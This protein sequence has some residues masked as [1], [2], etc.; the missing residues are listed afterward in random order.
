MDKVL[1]QR[2]KK[3]APASKKLQRMMEFFDLWKDASAR[4]NELQDAIMRYGELRGFVNR[5]SGTE[6][7][8][9]NCEAFAPPVI[10]KIELM[11]EQG[12]Q[13]GEAE[14]RVEALGRHVGTPFKTVLTKT[15][16]ELTQMV[17]DVSH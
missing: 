11:L 12:V 4:L 7:E 17:H 6:E 13:I 2:T 3:S 16:E 14:Q 8:K 9:K 15:L 5:G 1:E 10:A